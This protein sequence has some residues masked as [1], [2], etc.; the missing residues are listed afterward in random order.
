MLTFDL[1]LDFI[2]ITGCNKIKGINMLESIKLN[3]NSKYYQTQIV[4]KIVTIKIEY[5]GKFY[6]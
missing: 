6:N 4:N 1:Y 5:I 2:T 3:N